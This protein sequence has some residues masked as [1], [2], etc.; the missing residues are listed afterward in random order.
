MVSPEKKTW[1]NGQVLDDG[2]YVREGGNAFNFH[3]TWLPPNPTVKT[4]GKRDVCMRSKPLGVL[5]FPPPTDYLKKTQIKLV[6]RRS[7][8]LAST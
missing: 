5:K 6:P 7:L 3:L 1:T 2:G 8:I 4:K